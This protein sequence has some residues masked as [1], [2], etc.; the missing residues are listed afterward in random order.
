MARTQAEDYD[1]RREA[2]VVTGAA[3]FARA[4]FDGASMSELAEQCKISK[5]A[6]YHY[7]DS[8]EAILYEA[9]ISHVRALDEAAAAI[10]GDKSPEQKLRQLAHRI[11]ALYVGAADRHKVLLNELDRLPRARR[12]EIVAIQRALIEKVRLILVEAEPALGARKGQAL[13]ATMLFF[14]AI[15]WTHTWFSPDGA[16]GADQFADMAVDMMM[17]GVARLARRRG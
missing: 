17:G 2:I 3:L 15:N 9:M 5:S 16:I 13:A 8:K 10:A 1:E 6:L 4:G 11:M 14:G 7:F 12:A